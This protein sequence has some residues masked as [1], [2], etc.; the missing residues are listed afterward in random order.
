MLYY[1]VYVIMNKRQ[2]VEFLWQFL[3]LTLGNKVL[4]LFLLQLAHACPSARELYY[5]YIALKITC[6]CHTSLD[7]TAPCTSPS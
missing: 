2:V 3:C 6:Y 5:K 4:H 1:A 7:N